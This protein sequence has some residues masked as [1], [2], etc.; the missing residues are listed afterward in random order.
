MATYSI[1]VGVNAQQAARGVQQLRSS[2][3]Q[4]NSTADRTRG[5]LTGL[6]VIPLVGLYT[7]QSA[8]VNVVSTLSE[9][10]AAVATVRAVSGATFQQT[11]ELNNEFQRLGITTKFT[12]TEVA[13][14][15]TF[16]ARAGFNT[17]QIE[18]VLSEALD[19]AVATGIEPE[20][21]SD[22]ATNVLTAFNLPIDDL[23]TVFDQLSFVANRTNTDI[24]QL[25]EGL[26]F[27]GPAAA[28]ANIPL[29]EIIAGLGILAQAGVRGSIA[30]TG[31]RRV[32]SRIASETPIVGK[33]L[34]ELGV[35][36]SDLDIQSGD[37]VRVF[38][39]LIRS[40]VDLG[41]AFA[42]F[43]DRGGPA[44]EA[45]TARFPEFVRLSNEID[46]TTGFVSD[47]VTIME[48]SLAFALD[49]VRSAIEGIVIAIGDLLD[50]DIKTVLLG[51]T[52]TLRSLATQGE[53]IIDIFQSFAALISGPIAGFLIQ[54]GLPLISSLTGLGAVF[55]SVSG[56]GRAAFGELAEGASRSGTL[57]SQLGDVSLSL[58]GVVTRIAAIGGPI[59]IGFADKIETAI[60]AT[61]NL[62]DVLIVISNLFLSRI[63]GAVGLA[64]VNFSRLIETVAEL[65]GSERV[66][67]GL[68]FAFDV[69]GRAIRTSIVAVQNLDDVLFAIVRA[70]AT[71]LVA[72]AGNIGK[73]FVFALG[74]PFVDFLAFLEEN[75]FA[76]LLNLVTEY[77][78][79]VAS[80]FGQLGDLLRQELLSDFES[81]G[82]DLINSAD[83]LAEAITT[84][85][86]TFEE[87]AEGALDR[88][89]RRGLEATADIER[90][91]GETPLTREPLG[92]APVPVSEAE[93]RNRLFTSFF[94]QLQEA[95]ALYQLAVDER[96]LER[97]IMSAQRELGFELN[98][99][100]RERLRTLLQQR[101]VYAD[102]DT[103]VDRSV[104]LLNENSA[105]QINAQERERY[106]F[107][108]EIERE[109][110]RDLNEVEEELILSL[111]D[112]NALLRQN[113]DLV[114]SLNS[115]T[116]QRQT[117]LETLHRVYANGSITLM[118]YNN[119][120]RSIQEQV[121]A[122]RV[123]S[124]QGTFFDGLTNQLVQFN[125]SFT[126][127]FSEIGAVVGNTMTTATDA[128]AR[129]AGQA[130]FDVG[131][132]G[133]AFKSL[134]R[135]IISEI[136]TGLVRVAVQL[137]INNALAAIFAVL[138]GGGSIAAGGIGSAVQPGG[139]GLFQQGGLVRGRG[140][141][142]SD[143]IL[144]RLSNGE[145]VVNAEATRNNR[146]L[147]EEI[148]AG[149]RVSTESNNFDAVGRLILNSNEIIV[150][151]IALNEMR[152]AETIQSTN[153]RLG[154]TIT[155]MS[156]NELRVAEA[157]QSNNRQFATRLQ[158]TAPREEPKTINVTYNVSTPDANSFRQSQ[159]QI[160]NDTQNRLRKINTRNS[161]RI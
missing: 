141:G 19:L 41:D 16:L 78:P 134:G 42:L 60:H 25:A 87:V 148:N 5:L 117:R 90:S 79:R 160:L 104:Q 84:P 152:V 155:R 47:L 67:R 127:I 159:N 80:G 71:G 15:G 45:I 68:V 150:D 107:L 54:F 56:L 115:T 94:A 66:L 157:I 61:V 7:L 97:R 142:T 85:F 14:A 10:S 147:L 131:D 88:S 76:P 114:N 83:G 2:F 58:L 93:K 17:D 125:S 39:V 130:I 139:I 48:T 102:Q 144:A 128:V 20:Q 43:G 124:G 143:S 63:A 153:Q 140:T 70:I 145:F 57:I 55:T 106:N 136:V 109:I 35:D 50:R 122:D 53:F 72:I 3:N 99:I 46:N 126:N 156:T 108:L 23:T 132:L 77:T 73:S 110:K 89:I 74:E 22:I 34:Q 29:N 120:L 105:L 52:E 32:I 91:I 9:Y 158:E 69:L 96:E 33:R 12:A 62:Q 113:N 92:E 59:I 4:L 44:F 30:G 82:Q 149:Q 11:R 65:A 119:E 86:I 137:A 95:E 13:D 38:E 100:E 18:N 161:N 112:E 28:S 133:E 75:I 36:F 129:W 31:L 123:S 146:S 1:N 111:F 51:I 40:G 121:L 21:A 151:R 27:I 135:L 98:D 64:N 24:T 138:T 6:F 118:Q 103:V 8:L 49:Q 81:I 154:D 26:K 37:L 101:D 116:E